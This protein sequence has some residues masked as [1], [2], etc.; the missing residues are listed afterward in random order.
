M[1][2]HA[3]DEIAV[4]LRNRLAVDERQRAYD[5]SIDQINLYNTAQFRAL[6]VNGYYIAAWYENHFWY[7][8]MGSSFSI[9]LDGTTYKAGELF[10]EERRDSYIEKKGNAKVELAALDGGLL[11]LAKARLHARVSGGD[12]VK[13]TDSQHQNDDHCEQRKNLLHNRIPLY[14]NVLLLK[15]DILVLEC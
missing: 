7:P 8:H 10:D 2:S 5:S 14:N 15:F 11:D 9:V 12:D 1:P 3:P 13:R 6:G 4:K